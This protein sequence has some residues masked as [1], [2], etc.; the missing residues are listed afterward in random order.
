MS[1]DHGYDEAAAR[2][3]LAVYRTEPAVRRRAFVR[4]L[5]ALQG[6][7][8]V[9]SVGCGPGFEPAEIA[10]ELVALDTDGHVLGFDESQAML[11]LARDRCGGRD[12]IDLHR[13]DATA[14]PLADDAA[15]ALT[16]VQLLEYLPDPATTLAAFARI[17]RPGGRAVVLDTDWRTFVWRADGDRRSQRILDA[18]ERRCP[19]PR[20]GSRLAP[21]LRD[22]GFSVHDVQPFTITERTLED[23]FFGHNLPFVVEHARDHQAVGEQ[24]ASAWKRDVEAREERGET[25]VSLTQYCYVVER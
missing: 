6:G 2:Q 15:D 16:A 9:A 23:S 12:G 3:E 11:E 25:F 20:I 18:W 1:D 4:D 13:A 19:N 7:E 8:T 21:L 5:L 22:A 24:T 14:L 10:D 17:L